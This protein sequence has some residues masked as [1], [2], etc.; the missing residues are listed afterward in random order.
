L[1][2]RDERPGEKF[3]DA[4]LI[5]SPLR[6]IVGRKTLDDGMVDARTRDGAVDERIAVPD[7]V[8]WVSDR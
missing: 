8:T 6:V 5:G 3:A 1:D 4:D 7:V 2:D